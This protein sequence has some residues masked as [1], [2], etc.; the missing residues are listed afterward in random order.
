MDYFP[1]F[2]DAK[3]LHAIVVGGGN[4]AARKIE[5]LLK[6][7]AQITILSPQ[8]KDSVQQLIQH[9]QITWID[10]SYS[11]Q[12]LDNKT[13]VIAATN[14]NDIN[15]II[16][17]DGNKRNMLVNIVDSPALCNYITPAIIDRSPMIIAMSSSGNA[18]ILLQ[19]LKAKID[20]MLPAGYGKLAEF[21]GKYRL[22]VQQ[23]ITQF[24]DRKAFWQNILEGEV[25][26]QVLSNNEQQAE[27]L[28]NQQ[29]STEQSHKCSSLTIIT[30][31]NQDPDQLTLKA[32]QALQIAD[33]IL[34]T[35]DIETI[36]FD[37]GR[38]DAN[39]LT[40]TT[41]ENVTAALTN[42]QQVVVIQTLND[43]LNTADI[44]F[45]AIKEIQC[46]I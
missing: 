12:Y 19:M 29:L 39:K 8:L 18:P 14:N 45:S 16:S 9:P 15:K 6:T 38:R 20:K 26:Q 24:V 37:Y 3:K 22:Q 34:I 2:L 1:I 40:D 30:V 4:V 17:I 33:T 36:F 7:P 35:K 32:Y 23:K 41:I 5:L 13:L 42:N 28:F 10:A 43:A 46:G 21:C 31:Y 27:K 11:E 44:N 25:A